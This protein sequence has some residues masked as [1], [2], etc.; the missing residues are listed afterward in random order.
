MTNGD[1]Y[2]RPETEIPTPQKLIALREI[3]ALPW[4]PT[5]R[6][7]TKLA[8]PTV[9]R[10]AQHGIGGRKLRCVRVGGCLC[11]SE[12]WL[13]E[14]FEGGAPSAEKPSTFTPARRRREIDRAKSEL[15]AAGY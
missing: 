12:A 14:F 5:R 9:I 7:D 2:M 3:P 6:A 15:A 10:W 1:A 13:M 8:L 11:T 4:L